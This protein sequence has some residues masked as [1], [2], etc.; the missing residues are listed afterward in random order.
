MVNCKEVISS[1]IQNQELI[2]SKNF[3]GFLCLI[4]CSVDATKQVFPSFTKAP[5]IITNKAASKKNIK[6]SLKRSIQQVFKQL[7]KQTSKSIN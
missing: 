7:K 2:I 5:I 4:N 3:E 1:I 6:F